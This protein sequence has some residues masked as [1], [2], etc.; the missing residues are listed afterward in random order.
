MTGSLNAGGFNISNLLDPVAL[1]DAVTLNFVNLVNQSI[2]NYVDQNITA[3]NNS[4]RNY[5]DTKPVINDTY[6][7]LSVNGASVN[8]ADLDDSTPAAPAGG[9]NVKWQENTATP[10]DIS[11]YLEIG[12]DY[13][14]AMRKRPSY[15]TDF[16]GVGASSVGPF[17]GAAISSGTQT[18]GT[19]TASN[20][21][22]V[23]MRSST[24]ANSGYRYYL[25][26]ASILIGGGEIFDTIFLVETTTNTTIRMGFFDTATSAD[27]TDGC[28]FEIPAS[29]SLSGKCARSSS[30]T[31]TGS[32]STVSTG[33][34][35]R[36]LIVVNSAAT[37]VDFYLYDML[38]TQLWTDYISTNIPTASGRQTGAGAIAT[39]SF[40]T[41]TY[42]L[43]M[44]YIAVGF[45]RSLTR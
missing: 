41:Q 4:M 12:L 15:V 14:N 19:A 44:D 11:A 42:L 36:G 43:D 37:R 6:L 27:A 28:Y 25:D 23:R 38:G 10:N 16:T 22:V 24:T 17:V 9:V 39:N 7:S 45:T 8:N 30:R 20:P 26:P 35:Y 40:T 21:G 34:W 31:S 18:V 29:T 33:A 13:F 3:T 2:K 5:V 32:S 1:Y